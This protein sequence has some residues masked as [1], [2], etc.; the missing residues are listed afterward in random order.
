MSLSYFSVVIK[1]QDQG[2][3]KIKFDLDYGMGA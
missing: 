3:F 2:S 1:E